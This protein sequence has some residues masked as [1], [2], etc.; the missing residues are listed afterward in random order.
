MI[1]LIVS[2]K[3]G[4]DMLPDAL[5]G[6][7]AFKCPCGCRVKVSERHDAGRCV[8]LN[9]D[10]SPCRGV[11]TR[12]EPLPLCSEHYTAVLTSLVADVDDAPNDGRTDSDDGLRHRI[13]YA[14]LLES[15]KTGVGTS[16]DAFCGSLPVVYF[17]RNGGLIKIGKSE[18][19]SERLRSMSLPVTAVLATEPG[20]YERERELHKRFAEYREHGEWFRPGPRLLAY[21]AGVQRRAA[22]AAPRRA[23]NP[24]QASVMWRPSAKI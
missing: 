8:G 14:R 13:A 4:R 22:L 24:I 16:G 10:R 5:K 18:N 12:A 11:A 21:I 9:T 15:I 3:C 7:G 19:L 17:I 20:G 6:R 23:P 1:E 2:C